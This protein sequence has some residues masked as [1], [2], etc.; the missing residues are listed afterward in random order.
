MS[1]LEMPNYLWMTLVAMLVITLFCTLVLNKW[2][3]SAIIMFVV[4]GVLSFIL[5][6]FY[7]ITYEPLLGYAAFVGILSL[8]ISLIVWYLTRDMRKR[9]QQKKYEKELARFEKQHEPK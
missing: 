6:N 5:P 3:V 7:P 9:R 4:L 1:I 2:F 8:M